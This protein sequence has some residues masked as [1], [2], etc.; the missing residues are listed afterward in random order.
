MNSLTWMIYIAGVVGNLQSLL[1]ILGI[2]LLTGGLIFYVVNM[3]MGEDGE[4]NT[5]PLA[6]TAI[7][8][9]VFCL[10]SSLIPSERTIYLMAASQIGETVVTD[11]RNSAVF[12]D[13][14]TVIEQKIRELKK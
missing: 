4:L 10:V 13:L 9:F 11:K 7:A 5:A 12:D 1:L 14:R 3:F 8:G 2:P 6:V